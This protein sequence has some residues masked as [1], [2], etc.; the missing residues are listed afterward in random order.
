M[1]DTSNDASALMEHA[2]AHGKQGRCTLRHTADF[3]HERE[4]PMSSVIDTLR[5]VLH[6]EPRAHQ[7]PGDEQASPAVA[8]AAPSQPP[9]PA[10]A[11]D[12]SPAMPA[13]VAESAVQDTA[14]PADQPLADS[15]AATAPPT[16]SMMDEPAIPPPPVPGAEPSTPAD[17]GASG[18][19]DETL[20][21]TREE[22][23]VEDSP[24]EPDSQAI[25]GDGA[26]EIAIAEYE[27]EI[28]A[29]PAMPNPASAA[30]S[31]PAES[32]SPPPE[33]AGPERERR[34]ETP[35]GEQ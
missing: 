32:A 6:L 14:P 7:H 12:S 17:M 5:R 11:E 29:P 20:V 28:A 3:T 15:F 21:E 8:Q 31:D 23:F 16:A 33:P 4:R 30:A 22:I 2:P 26:V 1:A 13:A 10:M 34:T 24:P 35:Q 25:G 9:T 27:M 18:S 19:P